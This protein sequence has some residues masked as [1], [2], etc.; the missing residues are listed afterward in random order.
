MIGS[1][2]KI[3]EEDVESDW[4]CFC[5]GLAE[6]VMCESYLN[7]DKEV[8]AWRYRESNPGRRRAAARVLRWEQ[9]RRVRG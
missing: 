8:D 4:G 7:D 2:E 3:K 1:L 6:L 9:T 5:E